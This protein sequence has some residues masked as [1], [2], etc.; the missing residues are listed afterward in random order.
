MED[1]I[2]LLL[3]WSALMFSLI[4]AAGSTFILAFIVWAAI[5]SAAGGVWVKGNPSVCNCTQQT[6]TAEVN[7]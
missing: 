7:P 2:T 4:V 3:D 6:Q 1:F 5:Y